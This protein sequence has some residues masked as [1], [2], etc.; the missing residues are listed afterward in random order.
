MDLL[1][2]DAV[3]PELGGGEYL[4]V[5]F[6]SGVDAQVVLKGRGGCRVEHVGFRG[7]VV[8]ELQHVF[9][10]LG[11]GSGDADQTREEDDAHDHGETFFQ[12]SHVLPPLGSSL[13]CRRADSA[14]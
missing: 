3:L 4:G 5:G 8:G 2:G 7:A 14:G 6:P 13:I 12:M 9:G 1:R 10:G 11:P